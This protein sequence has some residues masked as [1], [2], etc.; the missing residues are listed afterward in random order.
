MAI[1]HLSTWAQGFFLGALAGGLAGALL[2]TFITRHK[3]N[4]MLTRLQILNRVNPPESPRW[5]GWPD[6]NL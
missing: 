5:V 2:I 3:I 6:A 1:F 4:R